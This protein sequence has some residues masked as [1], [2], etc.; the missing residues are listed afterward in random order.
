MRGTK[1]RR[2]PVPDVM[3]G[4]VPAIHAPLQHGMGV[5]NYRCNQLA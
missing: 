3:A 2:N 5:T 1:K 4:L